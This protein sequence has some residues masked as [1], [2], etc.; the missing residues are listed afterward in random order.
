MA[1]ARVP[2]PCDLLLPLERLSPVVAP[3]RAR[4]DA[5]CRVGLRVDSAAVLLQI[6]CFLR[7]GAR[8]ADKRAGERERK[9]RDG[10]RRRR[11]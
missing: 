7:R 4:L 3:A 9:R 6:G 11:R 10:V 5:H 1:L 8:L 2:E